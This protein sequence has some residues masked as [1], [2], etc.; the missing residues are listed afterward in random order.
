MR[1]RLGV[2]HIAITILGL[3]VGI[4]GACNTNDLTE[5]NEP[6]LTTVADG[7]ILFWCGLGPETGTCWLQCENPTEIF[8]LDPNGD[9]VCVALPQPDGDGDPPPPWHGRGPTSGGQYRY[10]SGVRQRGDSRHGGRV[11]AKHSVLGA[12]EQYPVGDALSG[13]S[14]AA[15]RWYEL[16]RGRRRKCSSQCASNGF[17][18]VSN[19]P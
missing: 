13:P 1:G 15:G 4:I 14:P 9:L 12:G 18:Y 5:P 19:A 8:A 17:G 6:P 2:R 11:C 16:A 3:S 7:D 10:C